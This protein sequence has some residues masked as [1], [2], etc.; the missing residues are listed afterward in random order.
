M[1]KD[2]AV[3]FFSYLKAYKYLKLAYETGEATPSQTV[4]L[5]RVLYSNYERDKALSLLKN[6]LIKEVSKENELEDR[7]QYNI[8][9]E[10]IDSWK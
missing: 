10:L 8:A 1:G 9:K 6:L 5:A 4:Y 3:I 7:D 2:I